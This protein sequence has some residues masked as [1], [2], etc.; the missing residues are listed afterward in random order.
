MAKSKLPT[1][2]SPRNSG[3][4]RGSPFFQHSPEPPRKNALAPDVWTQHPAT[5][6]PLA[7]P[8]PQT[9]AANLAPE[10]T[11]PRSPMALRPDPSAIQ[12][13][14]STGK[15]AKPSTQALAGEL[16]FSPPPALDRPSSGSQT[17]DGFNLGNRAGL[18]G[19]LVRDPFTPRDK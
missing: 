19:G 9:G 2:P 18:D 5:R 11:R 12:P 8:T 3:G 14:P 13:A 6:E 7:K 4:M 16:A 10:P 17:P 1:P 15:P